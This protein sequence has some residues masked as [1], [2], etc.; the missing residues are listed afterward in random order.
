MQKMV[1][2]PQ[3]LTLFRGNRTAIF[4]TLLYAFEL[5]VDSGFALFFFVN[6]LMQLLEQSLFEG[7]I[8]LQ[9][10]FFLLFL[11][12]P[13]GLVPL[14]QVLVKQ[15]ERALRNRYKVLVGFAFQK[16]KF[17]LGL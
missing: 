3:T 13:F 17:L 8:G 1:A 10:G 14:P 5:F 11:L 4:P 16:F 2:I 15:K 12:L 6:H 7:Q 9:F